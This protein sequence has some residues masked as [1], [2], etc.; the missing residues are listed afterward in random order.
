MAADSTLEY[1]IARSDWSWL[2]HSME[3]HVLLAS[4]CA[5]GLDDNKPNIR[6]Q[7]VADDIY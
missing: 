2:D 6:A 4:Q 3:W 7:A 5:F 1:D